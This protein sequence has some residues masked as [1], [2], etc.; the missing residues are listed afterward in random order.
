L[1]TFE[2]VNS[3]VRNLWEIDAGANVRFSFE[4]RIS[5]RISPGIGRSS[6]DKIVDLNSRIAILHQSESGDMPVSVSLTPA[7]VINTT[8]PGFLPDDY[9][10]T[11]RINYG[12]SL[13]IARKFNGELCLQLS[14]M[15]IHFNRVGTEV[16]IINPE[17]NTY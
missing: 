1:H 8:D 12:F 3:G 17:V 13:P 11:D 15:L 10:L 4:Y 7:I 16:N 9:L 5:N 6:L 14:P 2:P